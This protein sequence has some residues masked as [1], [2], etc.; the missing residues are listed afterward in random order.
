MASE[1]GK[2]CLGE[3]IG[4]YL[5][6]L[7]IGF[8][9]LS[10]QSTW[11]VLSI[12]SVL[13]VSIYALASVSGANFNPA[14][15]LTLYLTKTETDATKVAAYMATQIVAGICA[16]F[17][18]FAVFGKAINL[19]PGSHPEH[20]EFGAFGAGVIE[21]LY[22]FVLCFVVLRAAVIAQKDNESFGMAIGFVIVA[23]GYA[24]GWISGG[25]FNPAVAIGLDV[26]S[27]H[28]GVKWCLVYTLYEFIGSALAA[29][30]HMF[31]E[32][33]GSEMAKKCLSEFLGTYVLVATV[34]FNVLSGS[35]DAGPAAA[36]L[37]IGASLMVMIYAL[38]GVSGA[39]FNPAVTTCLAL[40]K[41]L[42]MKWVAPYMAS[43]IAGGLAAAFTYYSVVGAAIPLGPGK[44]YGWGAVGFAEVMYTFVLCFVVL[45][46]ACLNEK[47]NESQQLYL[48][49]GGKS[50]QMYGLAIGFCIV[51]GG[52]AIGAVSGGSLNPAVSIALDTTGAIDKTGVYF[53]NSLVYTCFELI[54]GAVAAGAFYALREEQFPKEGGRQ[55]LKKDDPEINYGSM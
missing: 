39:N 38:G 7:T 33:S 29:G 27:A 17:T 12:A 48:M 34:G 44:G 40:T 32:S 47:D 11:A 28:L 5:L 46:V 2:Q 43:Q 52:N 9:V 23:G 55:K 45:N 19:T 15:T 51:V 41:K 50:Y 20:G 6:I 22:T 21:I 54:G 25:C 16:G 3:F 4:T 14:V 26:S 30:V 31:L 8:N 53:M 35:K 36:A 10:G 24:G 18:Y 13:M 42:E 1:L 37:S 49:T